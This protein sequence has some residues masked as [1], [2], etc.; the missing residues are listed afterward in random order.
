MKYALSLV[1]AALVAA[2]PLVAA[3]ASPSRSVP[4]EATAVIGLFEGMESGD[5]EV[6]VIPKDSKAGTVMIRNKTGKPLSIKLPEAFAGVPVMAQFGG[7]GMMGGMGGMGGMNG[8]MGGM[9]GGMGG[10]QGFAGGG[11]AGAGMGGMGG[12]A[13]GFF[14][15]GPEKVGKL[16]IVTVCMDHGKNDPNPRVPYKLIPIEKYA[17]NAD[18][19]EVVKMMVKGEIDQHSAQ[20]A[21]WHLQNG[22]EWEALASKIG[23]KH[24]NGSVEMYFSSSHMHRAMAASRIGAQRAEESASSGQSENVSIGEELAQ[25]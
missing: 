11:M 6:K 9:G 14:N 10:Q 19:S 15:V 7:G 18:V 20:A 22:L 24:L 17:K 5:I 13:G 25:Q 3:A 4:K 12:Q 23:A 21:V 16:K 2:L 1:A 8:G